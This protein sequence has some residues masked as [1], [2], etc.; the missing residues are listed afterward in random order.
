MYFC[1]PMT[2]LTQEFAAEEGSDAMSVVKMLRGGQIT[3]P[4]EIRRA[5][6]LGEGDYLE[7]EVVAGAV[8]LKPKA[9]IDRE[10]AWERLMRI[11]ERPK[12]RGPGPEPS[13][14]ALIDEVVEDIDAMRRAYEGRSR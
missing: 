12:W 14:D 3:L 6:E 2:K 10:Q 1:M 7:A 4:A 8:V 5:L 9:L 13:E 11:V